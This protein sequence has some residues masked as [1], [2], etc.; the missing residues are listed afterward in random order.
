MAAES[1]IP[2]PLSLDWMRDAYRIG[3]FKTDDLVKFVLKHVGSQI[4]NNFL[5]NIWKIAV[6]VRH[7][8]EGLESVFREQF[9]S[10]K[11]MNSFFKTL[12][13][14]ISERGYKV[15]VQL[16]NHDMAPALNI[17]I[18]RLDIQTIL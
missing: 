9:V 16:A 14:K 8:P 10:R 1:E 17:E 6:A 5:E 12:E 2:T 7:M 3:E 11:A 4:K 13:T 15:K 18:K